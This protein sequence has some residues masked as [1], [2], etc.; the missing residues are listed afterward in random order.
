MEYKI[1]YQQDSEG[2]KIFF[3]D[4]NFARYYKEGTDEELDLYKASTKR[5]VGYDIV[6]NDIK[7]FSEK[8]F[9]DGIS[10]DYLTESDKDLISGSGNM[11]KYYTTL[12]PTLV[13][14]SSPDIPTKTRYFGSILNPRYELII[15][16][17]PGEVEKV[18]LAASNEEIDDNDSSSYSNIELEFTG[19]EIGSNKVIYLYLTYS[20]PEKGKD[21]KR[22]LDINLSYTCWLLDNNGNPMMSDSVLRRDGYHGGGYPV[23]IGTDSLLYSSASGSLLGTDIVESVLYKDMCNKESNVWNP[24]KKYGTGDIV[25]VSNSG[26]EYESLAAGN[27]GNHPYRSNKWVKRGSLDNFLSDQIQIITSENR[28]VTSGIGEIDPAGT[29]RIPKTK[30]EGYTRRFRVTPNPGYRF[31]SLLSN[32]ETLTP[33]EVEDY[34]ISDGG[35]VKITGWS[36]IKKNLEFNLKV[37]LGKVSALLFNMEN[38]E[39]LFG[40]SSEQIVNYVESLGVDTYNLPT[41]D[42]QDKLVINDESTESSWYYKTTGS[43]Q[44]E[45]TEGFSN[46]TP[47]TL[48]YSFINH[49]N[50]YEQLNKVIVAYRKSE[51][52]DVM[53]KDIIG[54]KEDTTL[55][56]EDTYEYQTNY[57]TRAVN[58]ITYNETKYPRYYFF[59][60]IKR[61]G[62]IVHNNTDNQIY[63]N[64]EY[65][66]IKYG[67][68]YR[69]YFY[70][71]DYEFN[72]NNLRF[73]INDVEESFIPLDEDEKG[74]Y[75]ELRNLT[76]SVT[77]NINIKENEN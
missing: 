61:L 1:T 39:N 75:V 35:I 12:F 25:V 74:Y 70:P 37:S 6:E 58:G 2:N 60:D 66:E 21:D 7:Y 54:E 50:K 23:K 26:E 16:D 42:Q 56:L 33:G 29:V 34:T 45:E 44:P 62:I 48:R 65:S 11:E 17:I 59:Y 36:K 76:S 4:I 22:K 63:I 38:T 64:A 68:N 51:F 55:V 8:K 40:M 15:L 77:V 72:V 19:N 71:L 20:P 69:I 24:L 18:K 5:L 31:L 67:E 41:T 52:G 9:S 46:N 14:N 27:I 43:E 57:G 53:Y 32:G 30:S 10:L 47:I 13:N 28:I 3:S 73:I 49:E